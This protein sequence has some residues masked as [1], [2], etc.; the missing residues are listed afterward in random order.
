MFL[1]KLVPSQFPVTC[2]GHWE[3]AA[4]FAP[5]TVDDGNRDLRFVF[6]GGQK[7][8]SMG[9]TATPEFDQDILFIARHGRALT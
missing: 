9:T 5:N 8:L 4:I 7:N 2:L 3:W 1:S 6:A